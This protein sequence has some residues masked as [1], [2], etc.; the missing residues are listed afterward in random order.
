MRQNILFIL[1]ICSTVQFFAQNGQIQN[2]GFENWSQQSIYD[3]TTEWI[4]SNSDQFY[5][6]PT[7]IK[8][9]DSYTGNYAAELRTVQ[10]GGPG[11]VAFGYVYHGIYTP[12]GNFGGIPYTDVFNEVRFQYKSNLNTGD[13]LYAVVI[14]FAVGTILD[15]HVVPAAITSQS[16]WT[17]AN[18]AI[19]SGVQNQIY[20]G[21]MLA[22]PINGYVSNPGAWARIDDVQLYNAGTPAAAIPDPSF[23]L[24]ATETI[25]GADDWFTLNNY[26]V[27][28]G[29]ENVVKTT[30]ANTG[31]FA[32]QLTTI[33]D[34]QSTDTIP[35]IASIGPI[36]FNI[37][38][39]PF[40]PVPYNFVPTTFSGS[41][42]YSPANG[43]QA[44]LQIFFFQ[45]GNPIGT[46]VETM[47]SST[48]YSNFSSPLT[49][50]GTPDSIILL[51]ISGSNP[52]SVLKLDD[53]RFSGGGVG[54][55]EFESFEISI[56]PNPASDNVFIKAEGIYSYE[57]M[58]LSGKT[59]RAAENMVGA[60]KLNI[61][62]IS[63]GTYLIKLQSES[64]TIMQQFIIE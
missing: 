48:N 40:V 31:N 60:Q 23:E 29:L 17:Q 6:V 16:N 51:A 43:D 22:D 10:V 46:H 13:T 7:T 63:S 61:S 62:D 41:Y 56:Y 8:S 18:V 54:I 35:G 34:L 42:K 64:K 30:D 25:E 37:P 49:I 21:F 38:S 15:I 55:S 39:N 59:I 11:N 44:S 32:M 3:Y 12:A 57:I 24:W 45:Q 47:N 26:L 1:A 58:D 53:L 20:I 9:T 50:A 36:D 14:R 28:A 52:G 27:S 4:C 19:P 5:G 33:Q 2:G